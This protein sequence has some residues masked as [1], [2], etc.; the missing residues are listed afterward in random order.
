MK[1]F[2]IWLFWVIVKDMLE[3]IY[4]CEM[5]CIVVSFLKY[6][7][8]YEYYYIKVKLKEFIYKF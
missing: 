5:F 6:K 3:Y 2:D 7:M 8:L 1:I 4:V